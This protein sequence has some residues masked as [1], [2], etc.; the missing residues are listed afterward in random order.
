MHTNIKMEYARRMTLSKDTAKDAI[1]CLY[2]LFS[3][4]RGNAWN[5]NVTI[6]NDARCFAQPADFTICQTVWQFG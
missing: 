3:N 2:I 6:Q 5:T 1:K 4:S